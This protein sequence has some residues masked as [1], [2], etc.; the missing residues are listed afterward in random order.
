MSDIIGFMPYDQNANKWFALLKIY[1]HLKG[2]WWV[3][4]F[5]QSSG[6]ALAKNVGTT[7]DKI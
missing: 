5:V 7:C 4:G 1:K 2:N 3:V 6:G